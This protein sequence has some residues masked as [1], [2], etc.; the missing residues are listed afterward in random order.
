MKIQALE[1]VRASR[2][3]VFTSGVDDAESECGLDDFTEVDI[4]LNNNS[5]VPNL[6]PEVFAVV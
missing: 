5:T 2:G 4:V 1:S 3:Y 6:T